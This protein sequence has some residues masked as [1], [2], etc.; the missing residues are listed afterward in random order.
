MLLHIQAECKYFLLFAHFSTNATTLFY[1]GECSSVMVTVSIMLYSVFLATTFDHHTVCTLPH[2][3]PHVFH[4]PWLS[5]L[6]IPFRRARAGTIFNTSAKLFFLAG[7]AL[8]SL[9]YSLLCALR[10]FPNSFLNKISSTIRHNTRN[11]RLRY[12]DSWKL[13][14]MLFTLFRRV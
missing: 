3:T 4:F 7:A 12:G 14:S 6:T 13:F 5:A 1:V 10:S 8:R 2:P 9:L 11:F